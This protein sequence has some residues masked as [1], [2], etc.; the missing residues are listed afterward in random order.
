MNGKLKNLLLLLALSAANIFAQETP[1][2]IIESSLRAVGGKRE[3]AK[4]TSL[5]AFA[6]CRGP[7]GP[8]TTEIQSARGGRL[9][10]RQVRAGGGS[11]LGQVNGEIFWTKDE[12]SGDFS[13]A[14]KRAALAWRS[15]DFASLVMEIGARF[16][17]LTLT[18]KE[19]F[20]GRQ[21]WKLSGKDELGNPVVLFFD[22]QTKLALGLVMQNPFE[23]TESIRTVF[24]D[25][26]QVGGLK[27][28]AT[29]TVTDKKGDFI[30]NFM[31]IVLNRTDPKSFA[32]PG[33]V[34]AINELMQLQKQARVAHLTRNA[35]LLVSTFADDFTSISGG[36]ISQPTRESSLRR[37]QKYL[38][39]STFLAWDDI[40]PPVIRVSDDAT[41]GFVLVHKKVHLLTK[42]ES[43][44]EVEETEIFAWIET[45]QKIKGEW[46]L[47]A[48]VSTNTPEKE[49]K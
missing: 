13:I 37:L 7:N 30:L 44:K 35:N 3:I 12:K 41:L 15:H 27:L 42:N 49:Q 5:K 11:Y 31:Q 14:D 6:D 4:V 1:S 22:R 33:K 39:S 36:K 2:E 40:R 20:N 29:V 19:A 47:V 25:W 10:F 16:S 17:D 32:V 45:Y 38:D 34:A 21:A 28:P 18:G 8:Y 48:V 46:K 43:G 26:K 24:N 23:P 9:I